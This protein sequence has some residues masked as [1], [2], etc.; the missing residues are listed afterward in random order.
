MAS[1][2]SLMYMAKC[3][4]EP[5]LLNNSRGPAW[6]AFFFNLDFELETLSSKRSYRA[7]LHTLD[8]NY[9]VSKSIIKKLELQLNW[10]CVLWIIMQKRLLKSTLE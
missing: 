6:S 2:E 1:A 8:L 9:E 4:R 5:C 10:K 3:Q 7:N